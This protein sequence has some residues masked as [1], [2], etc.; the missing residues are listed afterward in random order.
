[1][2]QKLFDCKKCKHLKIFVLS[3]MEVNP[4]EQLIQSLP[5]TISGYNFV[6][7]LGSGGFSTVFKV[8]HISS[9]HFFA[10]KSC[11]IN[12]HDTHKRNVALAEMNALKELY[13]PNIIKIYDI[14]EGLDHIFMILEYMAGGSVKSAIPRDQGMRYTALVSAIHQI[15]SA[16]DFCHSMNIAHRDIKPDNVLF[17]NN[18]RCVLSDFGLSC[19][20]NSQQKSTDFSGSL[21]YKAP[22]ILKHREYDPFK[23]DMWALGVTFYFMA[24]GE[25][26]WDRN[27]DLKKMIINCFY[28]I[29]NRVATQIQYMIRS[30]LIFDP[31]KRATA[32][33]LLALPIFQQHN[34]KVPLGGSGTTRAS[35]ALKSMKDISTAQP[36]RKLTRKS[37]SMGSLAGILNIVQTDQS[38]LN[39][40][41]FVKQN[42]EQTESNEKSALPPLLKKD[43]SVASGTTAHSQ[44]VTFSQTP[45]ED[46]YSK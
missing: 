45:S 1:M 32:K 16:V 20:M 25:L 17:D 30:T 10:A 11:Q 5:F 29:P 14:I 34:E 4:S 36:K 26:P 3:K 33:Q 44:H 7:V 21:P 31:K 27:G 35:L 8:V 40:P 19:I 2:S 22:E 46:T 37:M 28:V 15:L 42:Q 6:K 9:G 39:L 13:H 18:G 41:L 38:K 12:K 43:P 24:T 23:A